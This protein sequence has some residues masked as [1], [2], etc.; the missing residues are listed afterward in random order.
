L[1]TYH[2]LILVLL[3]AGACAG[4]T[5]IWVLCLNW[6][7]G[8][9]LPRGF[10]SWARK[11]VALAV[12]AGYVLLWFGFGFWPASPGESA[13]F[14]DTPLVFGY[15]ATCWLFG[16]IFVPA[17]TM[18]RQ[19]RKRPA[20]LLHNDTRTIDVA[21][22]LGYRPIGN[23]K[24]RL[25]ARLPGNQL[26]QVDFA[27]RHLQIR[28]L[29]QAWQGLTIL[30]LSDIHLCGTPNRAFYNVVMDRCRDWNPDILALT[31]DIVDSPRHHR[32]V[33]PV[34]GRLRW[35]IAA[36]A[37]LGNHDQWFEPLLVR[38]RLR[39]LGMTV[40][41]NSWQEIEV[42]KERLIVV[43]HEGPWF[44]P[45]PDLNNCPDDV[46][47]LCLSHT[48]DNI[49][50]ARANHIDLMLSGHVHGGQIRLPGIGSIFVPSR[51]SRK[52]DCG[53]FEEIPTLLHVSRGLGSQHPLR[54]NCRPEVTLLV[55]N[56]STPQTEE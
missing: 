51:Y 36:F 50:W 38:R 56:G 46:F 2:I 7:Y 13:L 24:H 30:H 28:N 43:G 25:L 18:V 19:F 20:A 47:R 22:E 40:L 49:S 52:Y 41:G 44:Q 3:Y 29:P 21:R 42:K 17:M 35:K 11:L 48:P 8:W 6:V 27:E 4:H 12:L 23:G 34:L 33:L 1:S 26:F 39:R 16:F 9:P 32:W 55:L 15:V 45:A 37:I 54:I 5:A 31:G 14:I 10:L 53:T